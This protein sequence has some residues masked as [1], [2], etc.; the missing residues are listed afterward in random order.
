MLVLDEGLELEL[1]NFSNQLKFKPGI[2]NDH[3]LIVGMSNDLW[4]RGMEIKEKGEKTERQRNESS[5]RSYG[6]ANKARCEQGAAL[7]S[8]NSSIGHVC[9]RA[10]PSDDH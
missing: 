7:D 10:R 1:S 2:D 9:S 8:S 3:R 4:S 5:L 6:I